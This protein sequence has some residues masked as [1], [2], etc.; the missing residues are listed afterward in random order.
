MLINKFSRQKPSNQRLNS[1]NCVHSSLIDLNDDWTIFVLF[2]L[3]LF[4]LFFLVVIVLFVWFLSKLLLELLLAENILF[5]RL[6]L[7]LKLLLL[8]LRWVQ[9]GL[10]GRVAHRNFEV[11][12]WLLHYA[13]DVCLPSL[14]HLINFFPF[15]FLNGYVVEG[16][17]VCG[18]GVVSLVD[19]AHLVHAWSHLGFCVVLRQVRKCSL[20]FLYILRSNHSSS[21]VSGDCCCIATW[22]WSLQL[23]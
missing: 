13:R 1:N 9:L 16:L 20:G 3:V 15:H 11:W 8:S 18:V 5:L 22:M 2:F 21:R 17:V 10:G 19:S 6:Q 4:F 23:A 14:V 7:H 12:V